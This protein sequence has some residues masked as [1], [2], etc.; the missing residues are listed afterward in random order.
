M[1]S[2][3]LVL[4]ADDSG[5]ELAVRAVALSEP[6]DPEAMLFTFDDRHVHL[7]E[8]WQLQKDSERENQAYLQAYR[9]H[10]QEYG[11]EVEMP[12]VREPF[13]ARLAEHLGPPHPLAVRRFAAYELPLLAP[14]FT[15]DQA[16]LIAQLLPATSPLLAADPQAAARAAARIDALLD[17]S[18][19]ADLA[20]RHPDRLVRGHATAALAWVADSEGNDAALAGSYAALVTE[21]ADLRELDHV[22][23]VLDPARLVR[24]GRPLPAFAAPTL[25]GQGLITEATAAGKVR[26]LHFWASWCAPCRAE[27]KPIHEV[28]EKFHPA[29]L[30]IISFSLDR[31]LDDARA[32]QG[33]KWHMPWTNAFLAEGTASPA[34]KALEVVGIPR[35]VLVDPRGKILAVDGPLRGETMQQTIGRY[36][37]P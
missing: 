14:D 23:Q 30:E 16:R 24:A 21:F 34:A 26:L 19:Q 28:Y 9:A 32:Y 25:D 5:L 31:T 20:A 1:A 7:A 33:A 4:E 36:L 10:V 27:M 17:S 37:G 22:R 35:L 15:A 2:A 13:L 18:R 11:E 6:A 29:G 3:P 8:V 12:D